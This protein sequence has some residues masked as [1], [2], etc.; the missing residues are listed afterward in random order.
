MLS[1][2]GFNKFLWRL[3]PAK[4]F[5]GVP[6]LKGTWRVELKSTYKDPVT[7]EPKPPIQ[8]FATIRQSYSL[9]S[10]RLMTEEAESFLVAQNIKRYDDG[11]YDVF[12]VYQ[13][14][15]NIHLRGD[16]SEIH[17]GSFKYRVVGN[18]PTE[19][20]GHYWTDR[21]TKGS[22]KL[23]GHEE[24]LYDSYSS[25]RQGMSNSAI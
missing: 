16:V 19:M 11:S 22:I 18:P 23:F 12:G 14:D 13:S 5:S 24:A 15:P 6:D 25:A 21:S 20:V 3:W 8:G 1:L 4:E 9:L 10:I 17:Y 2:S 7:Q